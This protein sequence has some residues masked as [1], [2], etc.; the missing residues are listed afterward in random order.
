[1]AFKLKI[2]LI[3]SICL[4]AL[5]A[6]S[7]ATQ[8]AISYSYTILDDPNAPPGSTYVYGINNAGQVIGSS[9]FS[10]Y[11]TGKHGFIYTGNTYNYV[12]YPNADVTLALGING[13]GQIAGTYYDPWSDGII[14][15]HGFVFDGSNFTALDVPNSIAGTTW[16]ND[17]NNN[18]DMVGGFRDATGTHGFIY[19]GNSYTTLTAEAYGINDSG[20]VVG[21]GYVYDSGTYSN[22]SGSTYLEINNRGE[23]LIREGYPFFYGIYNINDDTYTPINL[24]NT[25]F[26]YYILDGLN[27][28]GQLAGY[29]VDGTGVHGLIATPV[30]V[31]ATIWLF[32]SM[33][34]GLVRVGQG[35]KAQ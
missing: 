2:P 35:R 30:P 4:T 17:I 31:P 14:P 7:A 24:S 16:V 21:N 26:P 23:V 6:F 15:T 11:A 32:G 5:L 20:Q 8:A 10:N 28:S 1:M 19:D 27:D 18:G 33:L 13:K 9:D 22:G 12:D 3:A 34:A 29:F 25:L